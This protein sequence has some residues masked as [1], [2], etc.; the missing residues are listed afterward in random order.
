MRRSAISV[1][2]D[3]VH[4]P[5][6]GEQLADPA[7]DFANQTFTVG[8]RRA[9]ELRAQSR[10]PGVVDELGASPL[11]LTPHLT[12]HLGARFAAKEAFLKAWDQTFWGEPPPLAPHEVDFRD[13]EVVSDAWGRPSLRLH[14]AV[15]QHVGERFHAELSLSHDGPFASAVVILHEVRS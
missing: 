3:L 2:H 5:G 14:G 11:D 7:S 4:L 10:R 13:I 15:A 12:P 6:F 8:E 9:A 1:G